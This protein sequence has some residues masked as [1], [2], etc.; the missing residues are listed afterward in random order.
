MFL[1][2]YGDRDTTLA[3]FDDYTP[4]DVFAEISGIT[5]DD[6]GKL[7]DG[8]D[9]TDE[10]T[11]EVS[12]VPGLFDEAVFNQAIQ[13]FLNKK[14]DLSDYF[15]PALTEDIFAYIPQ[16][17]T[18]L[19]FT[20]RPVVE[21]MCDTLEK[22][23]PGIFSDPDK[24]FADLFSTAGLFCMQ[25]VRRL[26]QGLADVFPDQDERLRHILTRQVFEMS[27]NK[28]LHD[29]TLE[30]VSGGV[31]ERR[32]WLEDSGHFRVGDLARMTIEERE[33]VVDEMLGEN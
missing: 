33:R 8:R 12:R 18:S 6:F 21:L 23:N 2:A 20:P 14:A 32:A 30:A 24:T 15:N 31:A 13:E 27:P 29:I 28:I 3:N 10:T 4:D 1:M 11:G 9:V 25:I 22:E 17:K 19:V 26:D 5:E 16:Q 7:R